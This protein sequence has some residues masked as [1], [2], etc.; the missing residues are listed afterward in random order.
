VQ[1]LPELFFAGFLGIWASVALA[2]LIRVLAAGRA[3]SALRHDCTPFPPPLEAQLPLWLAE[4]HCGRPTQLM[5][6]P[7]LAGATVLG[8][9]HPWI[10]MPQ[11]LVDALSIEELDQVVLHECA[12][13]QRRDDWL[14]LAQALLQSALWVH[15][16]VAL[17]CRWLSLER[18]IACDEWV[19]RR[20]GRAKQYA[21]CLVRAAESGGRATV[22]S[23]FAPTLFG[24]RHQLVRRVDRLLSPNCR[25][26]TPSFA[27]AMVCMCALAAVS[28]H[29]SAI[30]LVGEMIAVTLPH[31]IVPE[32]TLLT[33][34]Q[35]ELATA[36][37][38]SVGR[39]VVRPTV[40]LKP[41]TTYRG[42][43]GGRERPD[44]TSEI[45]DLDDRGK[46]DASTPPQLI[47]SKAFAGAYAVLHAPSDRAS[48]DSGWQ[49]AAAAGTQIGETAEKASVR[50]ANAFTRAGVSLARRF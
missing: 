9:R 25:L 47:V 49:R 13:V 17:I 43:P 40:R 50:L 8:F 12:H 1:P 33:L 5:M 36:S 41:D 23:L 39:A 14:R 30:P 37:V 3:V 42:T 28:T 15:P 46:A 19:V 2:K 26:R 20:T 16:A 32:M 11:S 21:R 48:S 4:K 18:E 7:S 27:A 31:V 38:A 44:T 22:E 34:T 35:P 45:A 29:V 6:C 24:T 10:A